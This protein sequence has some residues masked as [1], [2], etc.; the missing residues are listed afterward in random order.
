M[1]S[2]QRFVDQLARW[3]EVDKELLTTPDEQQEG[4]QQAGEL[5]AEAQSQGMDPQSMMQTLLP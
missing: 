3:Y 2:A 1:I 5:M 4:A